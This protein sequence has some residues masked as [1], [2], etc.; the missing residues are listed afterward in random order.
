MRALKAIDADI[1]QVRA[2]IQDS[3][4]GTPKWKTAWEYLDRLLDERLQRV[5]QDQHARK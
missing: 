2:R 3:V 4:R 1:K 5:R